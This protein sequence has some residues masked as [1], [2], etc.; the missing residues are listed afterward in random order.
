MRA[1][2]LEL[3]KLGRMPNESVS[4]AES[5][6]EVIKQYDDLLAKITP[7]LD[8]EEVKTLIGLFPESGLW[9]NN[10]IYL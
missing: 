3:K 9:Y 10:Y 2:V 7:P 5:I 8:T 6:V 1:E 4:D